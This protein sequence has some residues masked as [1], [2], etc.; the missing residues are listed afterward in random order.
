M[1]ANSVPLSRIA[2]LADAG[3]TR[4]VFDTVAS[5]TDDA[6]DYQRSIAA[7]DLPSKVHKSIPPLISEGADGEI[8]FTE[9][10]RISG[11]ARQRKLAELLFYCGIHETRLVNAMYCR[12]TASFSGEEVG[13]AKEIVYGARILREE[14]K[15][16]K[17]IK[18]EEAKG[19]LAS[20]PFK[21]E[22]LDEKLRQ[23]FPFAEEAR[24]K[25]SSAKARVL[26]LVQILERIGEADRKAKRWKSKALRH[27]AC[28]VYA[29]LYEGTTPDGVKC[30]TNA[31]CLSHCG[32]R[33]CLDCGPHRHNELYEKY[34][35]LKPLISE[36]LAANPSYGLKILRS[37]GNQT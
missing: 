19:P 21:L 20:D 36:F 22:R 11:S 8:V 4:S 31:Y 30:G 7:L 10:A 15:L 28:G 5:A 33:Y 6:P 3:G 27:I 16:R 18:R 9:E 13:L 25:K 12:E 34:L 24:E 37:H 2:K 17:T 32:L 23:V 1:A 35:R 14:E 26:Q 29:H